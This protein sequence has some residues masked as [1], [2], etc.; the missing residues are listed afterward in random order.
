MGGFMFKKIVMLAVI[1]GTNAFAQNQQDSIP[2]ATIKGVVIT[3][4]IKHGSGRS[5]KENNMG[6]YGG[7]YII[8]RA[9]KASEKGVIFKTY[10]LQINQGGFNDSNL[11]LGSVANMSTDDQDV[12]D[13][14]QELD[15]SKMYI[16]EYKYIF[17]LNPEIEDSHYQVIAIH[18]PEEFI[19]QRA[20]TTLPVE[21]QSG[22]D[23]NGPFSDGTRR[24]RIRDVMR[25][26]FFDNFCSFELVLGALSQSGEAVVELTVLDEEVC[27]YIE[28]AIALGTDVEIKYEQDYIEA[29]NPSDI[30]VKSLKILHTEHQTD[31]TQVGAQASNAQP[32]TAEQLEQ[33]KKQLIGDPAFVDSLVNALSKKAR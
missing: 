4:Q 15:P 23:H 29:W 26:G 22:D 17:G 11:Y 7:G 30:Y 12:F 18:T 9:M 19:Q 33:L 2:N 21:I 32:L 14:F 16:F 27:K 25:Y 8:G 20:V 28:D 13:K 31:E 6:H 10:E 1:V 5:I 24:G 3:P